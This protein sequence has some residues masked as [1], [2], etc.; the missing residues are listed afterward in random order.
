[1]CLDEICLSGLDALPCYNDYMTKRQKN[2]NFKPQATTHL[3]FRH[4]LSVK[5]LLY[6]VNVGFGRMPL[7]WVTFIY[8]HFMEEGSV[9]LI[10]PAINN[11]IA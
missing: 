2:I 8:N 5:F 7:K 6:A 3:S 1:M 10:K 4:H 11:A 9:V